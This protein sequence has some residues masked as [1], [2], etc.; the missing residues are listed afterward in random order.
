MYPYVGP[1]DAQNLPNNFYVT[2]TDAATEPEWIAPSSIPG[3]PAGTRTENGPEVQAGPHVQ[4]A[5][6][7]PDLKTIYF[8]YAAE[9]FPGASELY[10]YKEGVLSDAGVLPNGETSSGRAIPA[11][12]GRVYA[13]PHEREMPRETVGIGV[14]SPAGYDNQVSADGS[15]IFF[16]REDKAGQFELYARVTAP[17]GSHATVLVSQSQL[18]G[19]EG[20]PAPDGPSKMPQ[21]RWETG[22][23]F[24]NP[25][26][27]AGEG[28]PA[29]VFASPDG[30]HA[31]F[32]STDRLTTDAPEN[33]AAKTYDFDVD[34]GVLEYVGGVTGAIV[35]V[36]IT[37]PH[38]YS[39]T[40]RPPHS[41]WTAGWPAP[42]A[43]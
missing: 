21:A 14:V 43:R 39:R 8:F 30:V 1:P 28:L 5:G 4:M 26:H 10:E 17:D 25:E 29:Y 27:E 33:S 22:K 42:A 2:A 13:G 20:E 38:S 34:T 31:F 18:P 19:H 23:Y 11:A 16:T 36:V 3:S 7:S 35:D 32:Q 37:A 9:L 41:S 40:P 24:E 15:R 6:T 12:Q